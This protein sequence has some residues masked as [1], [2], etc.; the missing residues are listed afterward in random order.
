MSLILNI[1][2]TTETALANIAE[3]GVVLCEATNETQNS[4]AAFL[5]PAIQLILSKK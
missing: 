5:H 3:N 1:D 4:H 2:T